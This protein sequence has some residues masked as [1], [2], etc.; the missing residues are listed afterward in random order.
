MA[1]LAAGADA[2]GATLQDWAERE[3]AFWR[4]QA[5]RR[6]PVERA[7]HGLSDRRPALRLFHFAG[8]EVSLQPKLG[9]WVNESLEGR[10]RLYLAFFREAAALLPRD[11][12]TTICVGL[13][14][15]VIG[16]FDVPVFGFQRT[17]R[18]HT[19]LL[20]DVDLLG[21]DFHTAA[22]FRDTLAYA[23]K[24]PRAVFAGA[25]TG[26]RI[27]VEKARAAALPR[28]R[29]ARFFQ[30]EPDVDFRLPEI[31]QT[32]DDAARAVL[33]AEPFCRRD[34]LSWHEQFQDR[35]L[36]S[37]DGNGA[38]CSRVAV[39]LASNSV[40]LKYESEHL[41][42]YF[43]AL[44]PHVHYVPVAED[45]DVLMVTAAEAAAPG[46]YAGI[47]PAANAFAALYLNRAR[48]VDY[49]ARLIMAYGA[50]LS[51]GEGPA[52]GRPRR[53]V[54][55]A[56]G[57]DGGE[58]LSEGDGWAGQPD[59]AAGLEAVKIQ[60]QPR[61]GAP[62]LLCQVLTADGRISPTVPDGNWC[63]ATETDQPITGIRLLRARDAA[64]FDVTVEACFADGTRRAAAPG[65]LCRGADGAQLTAFRVRLS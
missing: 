17:A 53:V 1:E 54:A 16:R 5:L 45:A 27:D 58:H 28:L 21:N 38:T 57:R 29:A 51:E 35:F 22:K 61:A 11:F 36:I 41:L 56:R 9:S 46:R 3:L 60:S 42:Y 62:R 6:F 49:T 26:G 30:D 48:A 19:P 12:S 24:A 52:E 64:P 65:A 44:I 32:A 8:G 14:D 39:A 20:P 55:V 25:T 15:R 50:A 59:G 63:A 43:P 34:R 13:E 4:A 47:P 18:E 37:M 33:A 31:V 23:D 7:L 40:L 2:V 10:A